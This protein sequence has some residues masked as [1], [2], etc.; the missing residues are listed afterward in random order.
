[1]LLVLFPFTDITLFLLLQ[2]Q[3]SHSVSEVLRPIT[4]VEAVVVVETFTLFAIA[5]TVF[6]AAL[7]LVTLWP[8]P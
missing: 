7:V 8:L 6:P 4:D 3:L 5:Q 1:M 2:E